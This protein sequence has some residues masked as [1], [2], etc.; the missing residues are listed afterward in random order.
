[1]MRAQIGKVIKD[2]NNNV[3]LWL[4]LS[5]ILGDIFYFSLSQEPS[6]FTIRKIIVGILVALVGIRRF[7]IISMAL[8]LF[9]LGILVPYTK[10]VSSEPTFYK[11]KGNIESILPGNNGMIVVLKNVQLSE[12]KDQEVIKQHV[13]RIRITVKTNLGSI[14]IGDYVFLKA[15]LYRPSNPVVI[16]GYDFAL[17]A[18]FEGISAVGY[19][20]SIIDVIE[21]GQRGS[22]E[23][24]RYDI[25][26]QLVTNLGNGLGGVA[27]GVIV[28]EYTFIDK[29]LLDEIRIAGL[30]HLLSVSG[31]H[32]SIMAMIF[33]VI[34]RKICLPFSN[35]WIYF[36]SK[37]IAALMAILG[38]FMYLAISGYKVAAIRAFI[39]STIYFLGI[40]FDRFTIS[41]RSVLLS[42][43]LILLI[44][45][46]NLV[47]PSFLMS[48]LAVIAIIVTYDFIYER[49]Y[50]AH[51][52]FII[53]Y[54]IFMIITS[55]VATISTLPIIII[56][57]NNIS[58]YSVLSNLVAV[59]LTAAYLMPGVIL[60]FLAYPLGL[61]SYVIK[62]IKPGLILFV[63]VAS[64]VSAMPYANL[65]ISYIDH[66]LVYLLVLLV[67]VSLFVKSLLLRKAMLLTSIAILIYI[68]FSIKTA[69]LVLNKKLQIALFENQNKVMEFSSKKVPNWY[70]NAYLSYVGSEEVAYNPD[71]RSSEFCCDNGYCAYSKNEMRLIINV[72][73]LFA[74]RNSPNSCDNFKDAYQINQHIDLSDVED[75]FYA[76]FEHGEIKITKFTQTTS[77]RIW[78]K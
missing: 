63:K 36:Y 54:L 56:N 73:K 51:Y 12:K 5:Y 10:F 25:T 2:E 66:S 24:I 71:I 65:K 18:Y 70:K 13:D 48:F 77:N 75:G 11:I 19:A 21:P 3:I 67:T 9:M 33:F 31:M 26:K 8:I 34:V 62:L 69:N 28:G 4:I 49:K 52:N 61:A 46:D 27:S 43:F 60:Y 58:M 22:I 17:K 59:P 32:I 78:N 23:Q 29:N 53:R 7:P 40:I 68:P 74:A 44:W 14:K 64:Y 72:G 6:Y 76:S 37:K 16:G 42:A 30:T 41:K 47:H 45:P 55:L 35:Y 39:M 15:M 1:M 20:V 50:F 38:S 57:F